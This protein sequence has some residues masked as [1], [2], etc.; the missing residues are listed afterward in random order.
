[1]LLKYIIILYCVYAITV[2]IHELGHVI[3]AI[4]FHFHIKKVELGSFMQI[5][6]NKLY[7]S[8]F[9]INGGVEVELDENFYKKT[10]RIIIFFM[11]GVVGNILVTILFILYVDNI[12]ALNFGIMVN[13]TSIIFSILPF[14]DNNDFSMLVHCLKEKYDRF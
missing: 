7:I 1:M 6:I 5:R 3:S 11:S 2:I 9:I 12:V 14:S 4:L 8:P 10:Y 13:L